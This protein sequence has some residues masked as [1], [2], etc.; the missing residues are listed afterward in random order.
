VSAY[1]QLPHLWELPRLI[2]AEWPAY[3]FD[4]RSHG[5]NGMDLVLYAVPSER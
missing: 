1:H 2:R 4:L 5:H 3:Q